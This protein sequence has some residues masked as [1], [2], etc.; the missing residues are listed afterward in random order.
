MAANGSDGGGSSTG[1]TG[2]RVGDGVYRLVPPDDAP[3]GAGKHHAQV[4]G[5]Q[6]DGSWL[7]IDHS[8]PYYTG[9]RLL[10]HNP[11]VSGDPE[12]DREV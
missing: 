7:L 2:V 3:G 6:E 8:A 9:P 4:G 11:R 12:T 5:K 1:G 10:S